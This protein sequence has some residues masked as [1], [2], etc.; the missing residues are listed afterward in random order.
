M[1]GAKIKFGE[2]TRTLAL[3]L[4][5][6]AEIDT[7]LLQ[8]L[9]IQRLSGEAAPLG[10]LASFATAGTIQMAAF[11]AFAAIDV[12]VTPSSRLCRHGIYLQLRVQNEA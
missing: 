6:D 3:F 1:Y 12:A 8:F 4:F 10:A 11:A 5:S 7:D 2:R 9:F